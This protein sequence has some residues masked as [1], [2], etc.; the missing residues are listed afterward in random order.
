MWR[1]I[2]TSVKNVVDMKLLIA[3][4]IHRGS[5][6]QIYLENCIQMLQRITITTVKNSFN[7][8]PWVSTRSLKH[9]RRHLALFSML[10]IGDGPNFKLITGSVDQQW[11]QT[12]VPCPS[13]FIDM[14]RSYM[15]ATLHLGTSGNRDQSSHVWKLR[16][17]SIKTS[18]WVIATIRLM[19]RAQLGDDSNND[20]L[21]FQYLNI[22]MQR[23][24]FYGRKFIWANSEHRT[25]RLEWSHTVAAV[26]HPQT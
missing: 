8:E 4:S 14:D 21:K 26:V 5:L 9:F 10:Y 2:R 19:D 15:T 20:G 18:V 17:D 6:R 16:L 24:P 11:I 23:Y 3:V 1:T 22:D 7:V 13:K 12:T 25:D